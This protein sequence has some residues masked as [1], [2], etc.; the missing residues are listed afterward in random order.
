VRG[1]KDLLDF[2]CKRKRQSRNRSKKANIEMP[3]A[4]V[5]LNY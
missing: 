4:P 1:K 3:G 2:R 5:Q